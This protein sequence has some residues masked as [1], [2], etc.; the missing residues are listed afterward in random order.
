[1]N[2]SIWDNKFSLMLTNFGIVEALSNEHP[3]SH[4][5]PATVLPVYCVQFPLVT[6][7]TRKQPI[8]TTPASPFKNIQQ[9]QQFFAWRETFLTVCTFSL[10][11][12]LKCFEQSMPDVSKHGMVFKKAVGNEGTTSLEGVAKSLNIY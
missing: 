12:K 10:E 4:H 8:T 9:Q 6:H 2:T 5:A 3:L 1:M 7:H 11:E